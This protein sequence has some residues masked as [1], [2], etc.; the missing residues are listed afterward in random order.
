MNDST[1]IEVMRKL[2]KMR[3]KNTIEI[4]GVTIFKTEDLHQNFKRYFDFHLKNFKTGDKV[5]AFVGRVSGNFST[6]LQHRNKFHG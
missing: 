5:R 2:F 4:D 6:W 1:S 3:F